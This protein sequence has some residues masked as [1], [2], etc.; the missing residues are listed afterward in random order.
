M[1]LDLDIILAMRGGILDI[2][3]PGGDV[4]AVKIPA[5]TNSKQQIVV[6]QQGLYDRRTHRRGN[7]H[8][9]TQVSIPKIE[10]DI[11]LDKLIT[12]LKHGRY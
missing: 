7:L 6:E 2:D 5:G 9:F 1:N 10:T 8:I 12:R 3:M 11:E 4:F